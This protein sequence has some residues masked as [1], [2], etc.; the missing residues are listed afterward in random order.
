M[1]VQFQPL[2]EKIGARVLGVDLCKPVDDTVFEKIYAAWL[3]FV[4]LAFPS[5]A[6]LPVEWLIAFSRRFGELDADSLA[7]NSLAGH[8]EIFVVSNVTEEGRFVG[9]RVS[10]SWH[11]DGQYLEVPTK[12]SMLHARE[13]PPAG[14]DTLFVNMY[15]VYD[16]FPEATKRRIDSLKVVH[17]RVKT[18]PILFPSW[19][20][21]T[22]AE[23]GRMP[24]AVHPLVRRHPETGRKALY[25]GGNSA[26]EIEGM[27]HDEG[28]ALIEELR[29]FATDERFV[30]AYQWSDGDA[31]LWDNRCAMHCPTA[32][33]DEKY[34]RV[35]YRTTVRGDTPA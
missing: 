17:S 18:H 3:E 6:A 26:W 35:M 5:Q 30:Y 23:K 20:P 33:D 32:F 15:A 8:G 28:R 10:R 24:D 12:A 25:V 7:R 22:D 31:V 29:D 1:Q 34:R 13:I 4:V 9:A 16:A 11:S 14:G 2:D 27:P 21:L 19:P